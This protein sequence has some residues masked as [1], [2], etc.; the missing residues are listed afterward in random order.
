MDVTRQRQQQQWSSHQQQPPPHSPPET[1]N[2]EDDDE[3]EEEEEESPRL[4]VNMP[5][6][7]PAA[8]AVIECDDRQA[9]KAVSAAAAAPANDD[10]AAALVGSNSGS[11]A[12]ADGVQRV[13]R[14]AVGDEQERSSSR[15]TAAS[16]GSSTVQDQIPTIG[17]RY[18]IHGKIDRGTFSTVSLAT[19]R[20][21]AHLVREKRRMYAIKLITPTSHP[22]RI[23]RELRCMVQLGGQANV[24]GVV[25]AFRHRG[26]VALVMKYIPHEPFHQYYSQL[27]PAEVQ[28]YMR[29]LLLPLERVHKYGVIH[30]DVKP[31]NFLHGRR[32]GDYMLV[33]FGLAQE[34]SG[35]EFTLRGSPVAAPAVAPAAVAV[36]KTDKRKVSIDEP[37]P[38]PVPKAAGGREG[39]GGESSP[40]VQQAVKRH[41]PSG[42]SSTTENNSGM[43]GAA[44][45]GATFVL[46]SSQQQQSAKPP[47]KLA[48]S[49]A[50]APPPLA[51]EA[52]GTGNNLKQQ[53]RQPPSAVAP[54]GA[55][56]AAAAAAPAAAV[57][58]SGNG[59]RSC[60][61]CGRPQVC[62]GC[63][64]R[65]EIYAPRAGTPGYRPPEVL[66]KFPDQT[67]AVDIWAVGVIFLSI[68]STCYPFFGNTD[69]LTALAQIVSVFGYERVSATA[70]ALD[71]NLLVDDRT[72]RKKAL[73]LRKLCRH[74]RAVHRRRERG[75]VTQGELAAVAEEIGPGLGTPVGEK[76]EANLC[77]NCDMLLEECVCEQSSP[78]QPDA[79][80]AAADDVVHQ[81][82]MEGGNKEPHEEESDE[83]GVAA[84]DLL[85]KLLEIDPSKRISAA[86]A[87]KH[88]YFQVQY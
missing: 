50:P 68:L 24:V 37:T 60:G 22:A 62:N 34:T 52:T 82:V 6:P 44:G 11:V 42:G 35:G 80:S 40:V 19:R 71:R 64:V 12:V 18:V 13:Q 16:G 78:F 63:L 36:A 54:C 33:D 20:D 86:D 5:P 46:R 10:A 28:R 84:Y 51:R 43:V 66:L 45:T 79:I 3:E 85:E 31:S 53:N 27:T 88:P 59:F 83:Y 2:E 61:C 81:E 30:R 76:D 39:T 1:D 47:L 55:A 15:G 38:P 25:D 8:V 70:R 14:Q 73:N 65:R 17:D 69:D 57:R 9:A 56:A 67:T 23:E 77:A 32:N 72:K 58:V 48:N 74:F 26:S 21:E 49:N 41:K 87:L 75:E 7:P 29:N 4:V